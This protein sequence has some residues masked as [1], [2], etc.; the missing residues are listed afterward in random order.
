MKHDERSL[1]KRIERN[2]TDE[3][4][5]AL[6][7]K[8]KTDEKAQ[9]QI[10]LELTGL[11]KTVIIE[12]PRWLD[13]YLDFDD[14]FGYG[15]I[16]IYNAIKDFDG[17]GNFHDY[18]WTKIQGSVLDNF[19]NVETALVRVQRREYNLRAQW[20]K[21]LKELKENLG[22]EPTEEE[23]SKSSSISKERH[24]K[25]LTRISRKMSFPSA[26]TF[27][28]PSNIGVEEER[29]S[30][31]DQIFGKIEDREFVDE[32]LKKLSPREREVFVLRYFEDLTLKEIGLALG[33]TE[34]N[35]GKIESRVLRKIKAEL[36]DVTAD[37]KPRSLEESLERAY[38]IYQGNSSKAALALDLKAC[39]VR[40]YWRELDLESVNQKRL[41]KGKVYK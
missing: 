35:A 33:F 34:S 16:G 27:R 36:P 26:L 4:Q 20:Q 32:I 19:R 10:V 7:I 15:V 23:I 30:F 2:L 31:R 21:T 3:E 24:E 28:N 12:N 6:A 37:I 38:R 29:Y 5:T 41:Y 8:A 11:V 22:R 18:A 17:L 39:T 13:A 9:Q 40:K 1:L 25:A 14:L